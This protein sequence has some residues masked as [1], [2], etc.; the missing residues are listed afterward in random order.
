MS[1]AVLF[2]CLLTKYQQAEPFSQPHKPPGMLQSR[3]KKEQE[4]D[5]PVEKVN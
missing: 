5:Q 1:E 3:E 2:R 4:T